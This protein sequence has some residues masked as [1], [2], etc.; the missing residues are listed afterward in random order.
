MRNYE[1]VSKNERVGIE[2]KD[3]SEKCCYGAW[4][5]YFIMFFKVMKIN[6]EFFKNFF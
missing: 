2:R 4:S 1:V 5:E 3:N 6:V